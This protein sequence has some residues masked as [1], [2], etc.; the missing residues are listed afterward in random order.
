M[1]VKKCYYVSLK[2]SRQ[3]VAVEGVII[4]CAAVHLFVDRIEHCSISR[5]VLGY[6]QSVFQVPVP[7]E[8]QQGGF[9][10][11]ITVPDIVRPHAHEATEC[12]YSAASSST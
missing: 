9:C 8:Y 6:Q 12:E 7:V 3:V 2:I 5:Q 4:L 1:W 11:S 10:V